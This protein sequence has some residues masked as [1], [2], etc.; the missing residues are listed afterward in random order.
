MNNLLIFQHGNFPR[1]FHYKLR[2]DPDSIK[3]VILLRKKRIIQ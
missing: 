3:E 1:I 2:N